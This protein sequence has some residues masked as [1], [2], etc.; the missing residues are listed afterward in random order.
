MVGGLQF[1]P[2]FYD[3]RIKIERALQGREKVDNNEAASLSFSFDL[4]LTFLPAE[5]FRTLF[6]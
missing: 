2:G 1:V 4:F 6:F 5:V 3:Q